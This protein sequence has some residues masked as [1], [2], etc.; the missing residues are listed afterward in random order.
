MI[1]LFLYE[2]QQIILTYYR[3]ITLHIQTLYNSR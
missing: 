1:K 3:K 2:I